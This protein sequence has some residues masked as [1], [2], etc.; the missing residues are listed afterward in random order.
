MI[1]IENQIC[2]R[3]IMDTSVPDI[4]FDGNGICNYCREFESKTKTLFLNP[5]VKKERLDG[6]IKK[7]KEEGINNDYDCII[8]VSGGVDSTYVALL[9]KEYGL[10]PLAVHL[11]NGWDS[12][13]SVSNIEKALKKLEIDLYTYVIDWEEYKD[14]QLSFLRSSIT[15]IEVPTDHAI[16][17][18]LYQKAVEENVKYIVMGTNM[19]TEA[20]NPSNWGEYN[21]D[22]RLI[23][24][25]H[26][27]FG[28]KRLDTF[29]KISL[30]KFAYY[31]LI[32]GIKHISLLDYVKYD[33]NEAIKILNEKLGWIYYGGKHYESIFTRFF[34]GYILPKKYAVDKRLGHLSTLIMSEQMTREAALEEMKRPNYPEELLE[35]DREYFLKKLDLT[36]GEF[37]EI[38]SLPVKNYKD[39]PSN[40]WIFSNFSFIIDVLK[41]FA[42]SS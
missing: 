11:D 29:P 16:T 40:N 15:N 22:L 23:E 24:S 42:R 2:K 41:Q 25:I 36:G 33:R 4:A 21:K 17:A 5:E 32:K 9:T 1:R 35:Q 37:E 39:Y 7:I 26:K 28:K 6:I 10:R 8:G 3:C 13:L 30:K 12:E 18:I 31:I 19:A 20:I 27:R 34:Q 14:L 38:M